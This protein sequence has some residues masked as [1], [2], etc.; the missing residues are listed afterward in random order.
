MQKDKILRVL[1][2]NPNAGLAEA[3]E[4]VKSD[5]SGLV[6]DAVDTLEDIGGHEQE[7]NPAKTTLLRLEPWRT[8]PVR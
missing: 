1:G 4:W 3:R 2:R 6:Q 8:E 5:D 7:L